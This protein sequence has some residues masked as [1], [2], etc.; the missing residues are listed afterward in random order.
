MDMMDSILTSIKKLIGY[1]ED[2][3]QFDTD[4]IIHINSVFTILNQI[5][6]GPINGFSIKDKST[7]WSEYTG[8]TVLFDSVK[9]YVYMKVRLVFDPP[10]SSFVLESIKEMI[11]EYEWRLNA[12]A[13]TKRE[14][15]QNG[16]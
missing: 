11:K 14:E 15:I 9:T 12:F 3:E 7:T 13:E 10:S 8:D 6:V 5:G 2:Y 4:L 1:P 16:V